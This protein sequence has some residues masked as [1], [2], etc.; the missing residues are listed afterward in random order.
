MIAHDA[1]KALINLS[2]DEDIAKIMDD[3]TFLYQLVLL[4]VVSVLCHE[5]SSGDL[6]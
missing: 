3:E 6:K 4:I 1:I 5:I 2:A